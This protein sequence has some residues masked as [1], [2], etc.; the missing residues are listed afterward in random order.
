[1]QKAR[2]GANSRRQTEWENIHTNSVWQKSRRKGR[3]RTQHLPD[4][5]ALLSQC[6]FGSGCG[7]K[8]RTFVDLGIE[9]PAFFVRKVAAPLLRDVLPVK[10]EMAH[11]R[12]SYGS[13]KPLFYE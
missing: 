13:H 7:R 4:S 5:A 11:I 10:Y 9:K 3:E 8:Q 2:E 6:D 1:M 12:D